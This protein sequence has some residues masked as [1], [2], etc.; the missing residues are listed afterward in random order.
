MRKTVILGLVFLSF[1][2]TKPAPPPQPAAPKETPAAA[3]VD[4]AGDSV[5]T[6]VP[7]PADAPNE[8]IDFEN[9]WIYERYG[10]F[11]RHSWG[12]GHAGERQIKTIT[13]ELPD[14]SLHKVFFDITELWKKG[15]PP[16]K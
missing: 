7:V 1:C 15:M 13:V 6:A 12:I 9:N 10:R 2:A 8:G 3:L 11:R 5:E 14:G 16:P 4:R